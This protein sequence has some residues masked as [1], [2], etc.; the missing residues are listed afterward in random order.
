MH[1]VN[2]YKAV[3]L[4][5]YDGSATGIG[6]QRY[7]HGTTELIASLYFDSALT[8]REAFAAIDEHIE[9]PA[10]VK[11]VNVRPFKHGKADVKYIAV[12]A[13]IHTSEAMALA[14]DALKR[15][16]DITEILEG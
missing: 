8:N 10:K 12:R 14:R 16:S 6:I 1:E 3:R 9:P 7:S 15:K 13:G 2:R 5:A 11:L 4:R